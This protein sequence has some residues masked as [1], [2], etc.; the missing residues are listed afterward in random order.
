MPNKPK[1]DKKKKSA[2]N[3]LFEGAERGRDEA[4]MPEQELSVD[5]L[6]RKAERTHKD[7][8]GITRRAL[9]VRPCLVAS[10]KK[11]SLHSSFPNAS[12]SMSGSLFVALKDT[13]LPFVPVFCACVRRPWSRASRCRAQP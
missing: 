13:Q 9:R 7:T 1:K 11:A 5:Q 12:P 4:G 10:E 6:V 8:T 2:R 3:E